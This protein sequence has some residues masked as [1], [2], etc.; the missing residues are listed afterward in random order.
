MKCGSP[1]HEI[2]EEKEVR[3]IQIGNKGSKPLTICR[4]HDSI[5]R[6][7]QGSHQKPTRAYQGI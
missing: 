5:N 6:K 3:E 1:S 4:Q 7:P 2:R